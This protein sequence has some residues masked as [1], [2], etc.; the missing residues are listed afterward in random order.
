MTG[1]QNAVL[2]SGL[3]LI[4]L[5]MWATGQF[6]ALWGTIVGTS[7]K[8]SSTVGSSPSSAQKPGMGEGTGTVTTQPIPV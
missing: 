5:R 8:S 6:Q 1:K 7:G 3:L 2:W 4:L